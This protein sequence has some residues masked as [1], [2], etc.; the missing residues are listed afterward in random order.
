MEGLTKIQGERL[1]AV[2]ALIT[3]CDGV[4]NTGH[5]FDGPGVPSRKMRTHHDSMGF[6]LLRRAGIPVLILTAEAEDYIKPVA[7]KMTRAFPAV[8]VEYAANVKGKAKIEVAENWL[9][10]KGV[11]LAEAAYMGDDIGDYKLLM[12]AGFAAAPSQANRILD[13][14]PNLWRSSCRGGDGAIRELCDLILEAKGI[15]PLNLV[16]DR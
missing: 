10:P 2:K 15:D 9:I 4:F 14:V 12:A 5:V 8:P 13:H 1:A 7:E 11:T 6:E 3:D 16:A